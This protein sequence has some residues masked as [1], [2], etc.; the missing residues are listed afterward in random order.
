LSK[1]NNTSE[2]LVNSFINQVYIFLTVL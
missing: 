2:K 1:I